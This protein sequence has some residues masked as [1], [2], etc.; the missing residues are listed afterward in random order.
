MVEP[1]ETAEPRFSL[2]DSGLSAVR[3]SGVSDLAED[4]G[5]KAID[6]RDLLRAPANGN[7]SRAGFEA[8]LYA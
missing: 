8:R 1:I 4:L 2:I 3:I 5:A 6:R 7:H